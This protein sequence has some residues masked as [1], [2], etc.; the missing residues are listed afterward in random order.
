MTSS[1]FRFDGPA[2]EDLQAVSRD[3][4]ADSLGMSREQAFTDVAAGCGGILSGTVLHTKLSSTLYTSMPVPPK[5][6]VF[7]EEKI[8]S[9]LVTALICRY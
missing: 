4:C 6:R 3:A 8:R 5:A 7:L 2:V 9:Y 1:G